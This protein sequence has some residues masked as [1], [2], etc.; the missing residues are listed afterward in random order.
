MRNFGAG[1]YVIFNIDINKLY[2]AH[3]AHKYGNTGEIVCRMS[4]FDTHQFRI[5]GTM[6]SLDN[7]IDVLPL[8]PYTYIG[9]ILCI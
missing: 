8:T 7:G 5:F 3:F 2:A 1:D 9:F 4:Y 6:L